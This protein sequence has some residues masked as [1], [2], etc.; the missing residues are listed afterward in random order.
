[1]INLTEKQLNIAKKVIPNIDELVKDESNTNYIF[2]KLYDFVSF[3]IANNAITDGNN[4]TD[5]GGEVESIVDYIN[6]VYESKFLFDEGRYTMHQCIKKPSRGKFIIDKQYKC[7][8][9]KDENAVI[10]DDKEIYP[11]YD[12]DFTE[13]FVKI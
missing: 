8:C 9:M 11:F 2:E 6:A 4:P 5:F 1:M 3:D 13:C 7:V 12:K 10:D